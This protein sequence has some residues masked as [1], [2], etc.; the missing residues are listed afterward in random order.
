MEQGWRSHGWMDGRMRVDGERATWFSEWCFPRRGG[1]GIMHCV[2]CVVPFKTTAGYTVGEE[3]PCRSL[4]T[5]LERPTHPT[6]SRS[7]GEIAG[8][9]LRSLLRRTDGVL[10]ATNP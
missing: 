7:G 6:Q 8:I 1:S 5:G 4:L 9:D 10:P 2:C 3:D